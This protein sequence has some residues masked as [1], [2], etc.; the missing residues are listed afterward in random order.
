MHT[1]HRTR[2]LQNKTG[3]TITTETKTKTHGLETETGEE[4][5]VGT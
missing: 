1:G 2:D 5:N 3:S 4:I